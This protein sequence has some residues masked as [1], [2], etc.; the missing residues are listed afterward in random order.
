MHIRISINYL[1]GER[2]KKII[3]SITLLVI[4]LF[5]I[6]FFFLERNDNFSK[7]IIKMKIFKTYQIPEEIYSISSFFAVNDRFYVND[8]YSKSVYILSNNFE[9]ISKL[10]KNGNGPGEFLQPLFIYNDILKRQLV[11]IDIE[12]LQELHF[13]YFGKYLEQNP[14]NNFEMCQKQEKIDSGIVENIF[15]IEF[16]DKKMLNTSIINIKNNKQTIKLSE[17]S[18]FPENFNMQIFCCSKDIIFINVP[19]DN[20]YIIKAFDK[21]GNNSLEI[22]KKYSKIKKSK[23]EIEYEKLLQNDSG[24]GNGTIIYKQFNPA[25]R[26]LF[27]YKNDLWALTQTEDTAFFDIIS[28]K[29]VFKTN[30]ILNRK[31]TG[32]FFVFNDFICELKIQQDGS[33]IVI[34]YIIGSS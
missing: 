31:V 33:Y 12:K 14:I 26:Q 27:M 16:K 18:K 1:C 9:I 34:S 17:F 28:K 3:V 13:D 25:I 22:T 5:V 8:D 2:M 11:V 6:L 15:K 30:V 20:H 24:E 10:D 29:G 21:S 32:E 23:T 4:I 7:G 19:N